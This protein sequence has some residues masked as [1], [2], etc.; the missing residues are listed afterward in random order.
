M[1]F[2]RFHKNFLHT[3][4]LIQLGILSSSGAKVL[5]RPAII[6]CRNLLVAESLKAW[7]YTG[8]RKTCLCQISGVPDLNP[9]MGYWKDNLRQQRYGNVISH[10]SYSLIT[11]T[12]KSTFSTL[13]SSLLFY[14]HL[15]T[16]NIIKQRGKSK[17]FPL[18]FVM[19]LIYLSCNSV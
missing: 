19:A 17:P 9:G 2:F 13:S 18:W 12:Y 11:P 10:S 16:T 7:L 6:K 4:C 15:L 3:S 8:N 5:F 1:N 14:Y